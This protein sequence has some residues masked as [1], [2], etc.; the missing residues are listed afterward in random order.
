MSGMEY[1]RGSQDDE[2]DEYFARLEQ[3]QLER[4]MQY[5]KY[6]EEEK[7]K[8]DIRKKEAINKMKEF[9]DLNKNKLKSGE[10]YKL[11]NE[12]YPGEFQNEINLDRVNSHGVQTGYLPHI[13][14]NYIPDE[15]TQRAISIFKGGKNK[16][17]SKKL[18]KKISK[19]KKLSRKKRLSKKK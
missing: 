1:L 4:E 2:I 19:K 18:K 14:E 10:V 17:K 9:I 3:E 8:S 13:L 7:R 16:K 15:G 6:L 12:F 5:Q 11:K